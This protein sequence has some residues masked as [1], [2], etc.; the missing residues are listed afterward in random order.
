[1]IRYDLTG[2]TA[3]VTG[4][5]SGIGFAT[6]KMLAGFG[7]TAATSLS[8]ASGPRGSSVRKLIATVAPNPA[9][10]LAVAKPIPDAPPVTRAV[11]PVR[12]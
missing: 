1:M 7:A 9:S 12:S 8:T 2:K 10:I 4:G 3:L 6:A 5:A 11:L